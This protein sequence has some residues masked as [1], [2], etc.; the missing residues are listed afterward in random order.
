[1][2]RRR[3]DNDGPDTAVVAVPAKFATPAESA[4]PAA[5]VAPHAAALSPARRRWMAEVLGLAW[6]VAAAVVVL[7]RALRPGITLGPFDLLSRFGLTGQPGTHVH[8]AV[9]ADQIQQFVPWMNLAW[10]QV[11]SGQLP[12]WNADNL[13]GIPLAFNWQSGVFSLPVAIGYLVPVAYAYTAVV[14][15]KLILAGLG[16]YVL[17]RVLGMRP[18]AAAFGGTAFELSGPMIVHAGWPHTSVTCFAGWLLAAVVLI[19][20]GRR[21]VLAIVILALS[22]ALAIYGGHPESL[23]VMALATVIFVVV[24][25][26]ARLRDSENPILG[27]LRDLVLGVVCGVGL[28]APLLFPGAQLALGSSRRAGSGAAPFGLSHIPNLL[29]SGLQGKNFREA[30]YTGV[31]VLALAVVGTRIQWRSPHVPA[32]A[33]VTVVTALLTFFSPASKI[34]HIVP[35]GSTVAWSR[36]VMLLALALAVLGAAGL[37]ALGLRAAGPARAHVDGCIVR[38]G[39][40]PRRRHH[41]LRLRRSGARAASARGELRVARR[42]GRGRARVRGRGVAPGPGRARPRR[43]APDTRCGARG[44]AGARD[45]VP[46]WRRD[47]L[48]VGELDVLRAE[49]RHHGVAVDRR[50]GARRVG[51]VPLTALPH[52]VAARSRHPTQRQHRLRRARDDGVRPDPAVELLPLRTLAESRD[53]TPPSLSALGMLCVRIST[54]AEARV[55]GVQYVLEPARHYGPRGTERVGRAG[56]EQIYGVP[57]SGEATTVPLPASGPA[58]PT[59]ALGTPTVVGHPDDTTWHLVVDPKV[60]SLLRLRLTDVPGWHATI[61]GHNLALGPWASDSML[62][63]R[64]PAGRH[65]I[66]VHY[67]PQAFSYGLIVAAVSGGALLLDASGGVV[68]ARRRRRARAAP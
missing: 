27:P 33:A 16:V 12:L 26:L 61:D 38:R 50:D 52:G 68:V 54:L 40:P 43:D 1:M 63:A 13:L 56:T 22:T 62:E 59:A 36:S 37:D 8:N 67:W 29:A 51:D 23:I 9:L 48:L 14:L 15:T 31:V 10:H 18:L 20:Q 32:L 2:V 6:T 4:A 65:V 17:C 7:V 41:R 42:P 24:F 57:G 35:D 21:R 45:G 3:G 47:P 66:T 5:L 44:A 55:Y 64:V 30:A 11:H 60:T 39:R 53:R 28:G 25:L 34:L 46:S 19:L 49:P 58:P